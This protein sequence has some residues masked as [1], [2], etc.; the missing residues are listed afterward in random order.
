MIS[1]SPGARIS[2]VAMHVELFSTGLNPVWQHLGHIPFLNEIE[3]LRNPKFMGN[4]KVVV[5]FNNHP[6]GS[7]V[8]RVQVIRLYFLVLTTD[9]KGVV[10]MV[11]D[12]TFQW[13]IH[14]RDKC[15]PLVV[16]KKQFEVSLGR[17]K[18]KGVP[19]KVRGLKLR[20]RP[21]WT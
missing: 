19:L 2:Q 15:E 18:D 14:D 4:V 12:T 10:N 1:P 17:S 21:W 7:E 16:W 3:P 11:L 6:D 8:V 20:T 9:R 5:D 13:E